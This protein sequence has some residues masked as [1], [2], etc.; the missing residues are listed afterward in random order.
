VYKLFQYGLFLAFSIWE[1]VD[2]DKKLVLTKKI[3]QMVLK[4]EKEMVLNFLY[5][6]VRF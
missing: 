1:E 4:F 6:L 3:E 5:N 2:K